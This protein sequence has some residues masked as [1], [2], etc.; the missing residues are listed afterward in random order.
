M[1]NVAAAEAPAR[2]F[3]WLRVP[4]GLLTAAGVVFA[5]LLLLEIGTRIGVVPRFL[6]PQPS[7]VLVA[8]FE[9]LANGHLV[10]HAGVTTFEALSGFA[11]A[12]VLGLVLAV[13]IAEVRLME[14]AV[15]PWLVAIQATPKI[16][17]APLFIIW[18][19]FGVSSKIAVATM[20]CLFP[21]LV[22]TITGLHATPPG[23]IETARSMGASRWQ[24][25]RYIRFPS[26]LPHIF[27]GF[28]LASVFAFTGAIVGEFIG[29]S[30]GLGHL[31]L[32]ANSRIRLDEAFAA[33]IVVALL[34]LAFFYA[35]DFAS[36]RLLTWKH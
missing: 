3:R 19:G 25:L 11:I 24:V 34:G 6:I 17:L 10:Y 28:S 9:G 18:F 22:T 2:P 16:A 36:R 30:A 33:L 1:S 8:L 32:E 5:A 27:A 21:V 4:R 15:Y 14:R 31:V 26:A 12:C 7:A 29:A 35:I 20:I 23:L 13:L